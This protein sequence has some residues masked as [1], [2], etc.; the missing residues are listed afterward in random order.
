[1][2]QHTYTEFVPS[3]TKTVVENLPPGRFLDKDEVLQ[4]GDLCLNPGAKSFKTPMV[5]LTGWDAGGDKYYRPGPVNK[6]EPGYY[7]LKHREDVLHG[8]EQCVDQAEWKTGGYVGC[9]VGLGHVGKFRRKIVTPEPK[10]KVGQTVK[11]LQEGRK[12]QI[13]K[14]VR[15]LENE[16]PESWRNFVKIDYDTPKYADN[17]LEL[18]ENVAPAKAVKKTSKYR[19]L[20]PDEIIQ[21][22]DQYYAEETRGWRN[23]TNSTGWTKTSWNN[24][25]YQTVKRFRRKV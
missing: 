1:M 9:Y 19:E 15:I 2:N 12:G 17:E 7:Y 4:E 23:V 10:F 20:G 11:I 8:D 6:E 22:G 3:S 16:S 18:V 25:H 14:V 5:G 13:G 24:S 21:K